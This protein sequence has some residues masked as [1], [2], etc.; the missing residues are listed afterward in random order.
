MV[1]TVRGVPPFLGMRLIRP[2]ARSETRASPSGRKA[3][4]QGALSPE[5][6]PFGA[7]LGGSV[8]R[9]LGVDLA[10]DLRLDAVVAHGRRCGEAL[11]EIAALQQAALVRRVAPDAC[12]AVGLQLGADRQLVGLARVG[13]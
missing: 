4:P 5:A 9:R 6:E 3:M 1:L 8:R 7:L 13:A 10:R 11:L 12:Q 2:V